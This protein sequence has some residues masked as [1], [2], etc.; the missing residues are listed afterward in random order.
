MFEKSFKIIVKKLD[1][2]FPL[3]P[4]ESKEV[5]YYLIK[6]TPKCTGLGENVKCDVCVE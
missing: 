3:L 2:E 5:G 4:F 1:E 6:I